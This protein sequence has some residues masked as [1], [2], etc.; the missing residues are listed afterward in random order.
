MA[1]LSLVASPK[2]TAGIQIP[3][4]GGDSV[5]VEFTFR[6]RTKRELGE[7]IAPE[8]ERDDLDTVMEC[9]VGWEL[10]EECTR[11]NVDIFLQNYGGAA[12]AIYVGYL[13]E[14]TGQ[15]QKN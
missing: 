2:F 14:I 8:N 7:F 12:L 6:H 4:A 5:I 13:D 10:A 11:E 15:R 3:V 9:I 1:K